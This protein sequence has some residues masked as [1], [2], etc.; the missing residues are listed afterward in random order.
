[1]RLRRVGA[2]PGQSKAKPQRCLTPRTARRAQAW[3][4][5]VVLRFRPGPLLKG[6]APGAVEPRQ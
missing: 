1:V 5:A 6:M 2:G 3:V 4:F